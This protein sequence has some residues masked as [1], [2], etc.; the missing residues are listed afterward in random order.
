LKGQGAAGDYAFFPEM[1]VGY[2][3]TD[4]M[5]P[6]RFVHPS[7]IVNEPVLRAIEGPDATSRSEILSIFEKEPRFVV[8]RDDVFYLRRR[9]EAKRLIE[10]ILAKDYAVTESVEAFRIYVRKAS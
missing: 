6:T 8:M 10:E 5:I 3:L 1:H 2:L 7:L 4:T 9:P